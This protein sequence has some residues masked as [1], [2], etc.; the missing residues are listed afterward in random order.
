MFSANTATSCLAQVPDVNG[1]ENPTLKTVLYGRS[2]TAS[3]PPRA[4]RCRRHAARPRDR[5]AHPRLEASMPWRTAGLVCRKITHPR[6]PAALWRRATMMKDFANRRACGGNCRGRSSSR[7]CVR[8][9]ALCRSRWRRPSATSA[10]ARLCAILLGLE[11]CR[12]R[13]IAR[14]LTDARTPGVAS[15]LVRTSSF[16]LA[17]SRRALAWQRGPGARF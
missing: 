10:A 3:H 15:S 7:H 8:R 4:T 17:S 9:S 5:R 16:G 11:S 13:H 1:S 14:T 6:Q 2:T 12:G